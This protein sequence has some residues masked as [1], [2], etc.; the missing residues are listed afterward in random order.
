[1]LTSSTREI[2]KCLDILARMRNKWKGADRCHAA[3]STSVS[4]LSKRRNQYGSASSCALSKRPHGSDAGLLPALSRKRPCLN[5]GETVNAG[6]KLTGP[7][8][9]PTYQAWSSGDFSISRD[10]LP[11]LDIGNGDMF[12]DISWDGDFSSVDHFTLHG[13]QQDWLG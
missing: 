10:P 8:P 5:Q 3:L 2:N 1:M 6:E 9:A 7:P 12:Q 13:F 11:G 4:N